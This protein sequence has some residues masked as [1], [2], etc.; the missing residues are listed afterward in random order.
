GVDFNKKSDS[1][2]SPAEKLARSLGLQSGVRLGAFFLFERKIGSS[3]KKEYKILDGRV[4]GKRGEMQETNRILNDYA[5][6]GFRPLDLWF[7]GFTTQNLVI[8]E[9]DEAIKPEGEYLMIYQ[10]L[11]LNKKLNELG[12]EGF[13]PI[14]IGFV[15]ALLQ[16]TKKEPTNKIYDT[17]QT[18]KEIEKRLPQWK[19]SGMKYIDTGISDYYTNYDPFDGKW[20]FAIPEKNNSEYGKNKDF[21]FV[22]YNAIAEEYYKKNGFKPTEKNPLTPQQHQEINNIFGKELNRLAKEGYRLVTF[23]NPNSIVA[24]FEK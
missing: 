16:R 22:R 21:K 14:S 4:S 17:V 6:K 9:K 18:W 13:E 12:H 2:E 23:G 1:E 15:F 19:Q 20:L 8:A 3:I 7:T 10:T 5:A 24:M 11:G